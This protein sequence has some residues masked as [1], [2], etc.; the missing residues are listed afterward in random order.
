[1]VHGRGCFE[2]IT[3]N[4]KGIHNNKIKGRELP[5]PANMVK[6][7]IS[8]MSTLESGADNMCRSLVPKDGRKARQV[9]ERDP[10]LRREL[11]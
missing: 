3:F 2:K 7:S 8:G 6:S 11:H 10:L 5:S 4:H 1:M 9:G